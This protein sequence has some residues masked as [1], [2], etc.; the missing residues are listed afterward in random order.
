MNPAEDAER[1]G[2]LEQRWSRVSESLR[3]IGRLW[4]ANWS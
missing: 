1:L 3:L 4:M 2:N